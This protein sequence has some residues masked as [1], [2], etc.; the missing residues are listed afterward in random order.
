MNIDSQSV[1]QDFALNNKVNNAN[2]ELAEQKVSESVPDTNKLEQ[3]TKGLSSS[4][5]IGQ[6]EIAKVTSEQIDRAVLELSE[7]AQVNNRQLDFSI[8]EDSKKQV[9]KVTDTESG[10]VIRQIPS[11]E[12]LQVS[13]RLRDLHTDVGS[14]VGVLFN[15]QA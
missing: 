14:A 8:D 5:E 11:E 4:A 7:F 10:E 15:K 1:G 2:P 12:I 13:T 6:R 9:V 3:L